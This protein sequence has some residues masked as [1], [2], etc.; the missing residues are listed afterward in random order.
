MGAEDRT[1]TNLGANDLS[2]SE[3]TRDSK[4]RGN[5][6]TQLW[7]LQNFQPLYSLSSQKQEVLTLHILSET[8]E[9]KYIKILISEYN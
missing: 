4:L 1:T 8:Y 6:R 9:S 5:L 7:S 3:D 2:S